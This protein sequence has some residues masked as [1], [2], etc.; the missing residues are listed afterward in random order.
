MN[1][2]WD[3]AMTGRRSASLGSEKYQELLSASGLSLIE[4]FEDE[5]GNHYFNAIKRV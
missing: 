3:D 2:D 1:V 4:E 5:G